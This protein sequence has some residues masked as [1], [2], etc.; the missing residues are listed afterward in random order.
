M[1]R[2]V[3]AAVVSYPIRSGAHN[4]RALILH[5]MS[6]ALGSLAVVISS[7]TIWLSG[8]QWANYL[9]PV[10]SVV[11]VVFTAA[12]TVPLVKSASVILM[13][14][15]PLGVGVQELQDAVDAIPG[16]VNVHE[17]H[18]WQLTN[19]KMI[20]SVHIVCSKAEYHDIAQHIKR[21]L[22]HAGVHSSTIQACICIAIGSACWAY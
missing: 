20:A 14:G 4:T 3:T 9:D 22:H 7:L 18:I 6:D 17:L 1:A 2:F 13:Q 10:C 5:L 16:V 12:V 21:V 19:T 15:V 8:E 11:I